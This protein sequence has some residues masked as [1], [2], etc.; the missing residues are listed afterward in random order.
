MAHPGP[1]SHPRRRGLVR[2]LVPLVLWC[3]ALGPGMGAAAAQVEVAAELERMMTQYGFA[4]KPAD[5]DATRDKKARAEEGA[6]V[7]PRLRVLLEGFDHIIV[8]AP[9]GGVERVLILGAKTPYSPPAP[10]TAT[11]GAADPAGAAGEIVL[12]TQRVGSSHAVTLTLEG[13]DGRRVSRVLLVD[14]G[15][16]YVVLP[17]SLIAQLGIPPEGLRQQQVQTANGNVEAALGTLQAVWLKDQRVTGVPVAFIEDGRLGG[18]ALLGM[19]L[20]GRFRLTIEDE[21]NRL[22]LGTK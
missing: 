17:S 6:E 4:M 18:N 21:K 16:D 15:A 7:L 1:R 10:A 14:T 3:C 8:Q 12:D 11:P 20:L 22:L 5:L 19:S 13:E 2:P 9:Q